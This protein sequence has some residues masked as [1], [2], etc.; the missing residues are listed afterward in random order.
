MMLSVAVDGSRTCATRSPGEGE[1][2]W[3]NPLVVK[4]VAKTMAATAAA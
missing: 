4:N 2:D 3:A 1:E